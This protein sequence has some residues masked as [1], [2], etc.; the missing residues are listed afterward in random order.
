MVTDLVQRRMLLG[1]NQ[2][3]M[4]SLLGRPDSSYSVKEACERP[5]YGNGAREQCLARYGPS[6]PES[7]ASCSYKLGY[8]GGDPRGAF[9]FTW[10]LH[11]HFE[12]GVIQSTVV[13][14]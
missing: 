8:M 10:D 6:T 11:V 7:F 4:V 3:E 13:D 9:S 12:H 1:L 2:T 14:D 5:G